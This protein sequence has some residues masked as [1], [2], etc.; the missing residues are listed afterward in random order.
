MDL[1]NLRYVPWLDS[2]LL[3]H[4]LP[5]I[6]GEGLFILAPREPYVC[7]GYH[8]D[9]TREID[10]D[11]CQEHNIPIFRRE[12]GGGAVY[13]DSNQI[14]YQVI[15]REDNP[16]AQGSKQTLYERLLRPVVN[17]YRDLGVDVDYRPVNDIVTKEGRKIAGTGAATI[18]GYIVL[19]GNMIVDF[20]YDTMAKVLRVPDEK[21]RDHVHKSM[22]ENLT[23]LQR[24]TGR[25]FTWYQVAVPLVRRFGEVLGPIKPALITK[26]L[27]QEADSL[28]SR[29]YSDDWLYRVNRRQTEFNTRIASGVNVQQ[30]LYKAAGGLLRA[31]MEVKDD[32]LVNVSLSGDFFCYPEDAISTLETTLKN[33]PLDNLT[34][35]LNRFYR[36]NQ[37]ETPGVTTD[38]WLKLLVK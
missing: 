19:V 18:A 13:L 9:V 12:V 21:Y 34:E 5:R 8:Q 24:E 31:T 2:Q 32:I 38:D 1:Y 6:G 17:A 37:V 20:D 27:R 15:L 11:Y 28:K 36:D 7:I 3:Y 23:T 25:E 26:T 33:V 14:F 10:I 35:A 29:L 4:A 30:R 22:Y 16:L